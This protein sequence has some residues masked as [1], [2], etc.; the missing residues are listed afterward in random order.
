M[1]DLVRLLDPRFHCRGRGVHWCEYVIE[2]NQ[3][4][5][6]KG[7]IW[8]V[9]SPTRTLLWFGQPSKRFADFPGAARCDIYRCEP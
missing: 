5:G 7:D 8:P 9:Q 2:Q 6:F 1:S 4:I 3:K